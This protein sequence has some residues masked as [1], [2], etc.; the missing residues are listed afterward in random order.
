MA[1]KETPQLLKVKDEVINEVI[2]E[3]E[4][5][6]IT[7]IR[8]LGVNTYDMKRCLKIS[9]LKM[10]CVYLLGLGLVK[11]LRNTFDIN[12][13]IK[14][15]YIVCK[16]GKSIDLQRRLG[17]HELDYGKMS[18]VLISIIKYAYIDPEYLNNAELC[19]SHIFNITEN[20]LLGSKRKELIF[21]KKSNLKFVKEYFESLQ[22]R[23]ICQYKEQ[24]HEIEK[25]QL[26]I[27]SKEKEIENKNLIIKLKNKEI[28][29][30]K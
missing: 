2:N 7:L 24:I 10:S 28:E 13:T 27:N 14:D 3:V 23:F 8:E 30:L 25:K 26:I 21:I 29:N 6:K 12:E 15:E 9:T 16:F 4:E 17:E 1:S 11:D 5:V 19:V 20:K 22:K 18:G